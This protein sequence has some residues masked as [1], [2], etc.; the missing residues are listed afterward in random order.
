MNPASV[1]NPFAQ[2]D[3]WALRRLAFALVLALAALAGCA[4]PQP[5]ARVPYQPP[6]SGPQALLTVQTQK[7]WMPNYVTL[8]L[9]RPLPDRKDGELHRVGQLQSGENV[10]EMLTFD[11]RLPA[12]VPLPLYF[13]YRYDIRGAVDTGCDYAVTLTLEAGSRYLVDFIKDTRSCSPKIYV[14]GQD[15]TRTEIAGQRR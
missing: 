15:G 5:P 14:I 2:P 1:P 7:M 8:Y 13:E 6:A 12:G 3:A 9:V 10:R 11:A 4:K